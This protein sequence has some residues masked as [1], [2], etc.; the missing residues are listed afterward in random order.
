[1]QKYSSWCDAFFMVL[2]SFGILKC[3]MTFKCAFAFFCDFI[4]F[5]SH[6]LINLETDEF[7]GIHTKKMI[8]ISVLFYS[9]L[10]IFQQEYLNWKILFLQSN[11]IIYEQMII[12]ILYFA[13]VIWW[14]RTFSRCK[15]HCQWIRLNWLNICKLMW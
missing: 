13:W 3:E 10:L 1:M 7:Q 2:M 6:R 9:L 4:W 8:K 12:C 5:L 15:S 11:I 14:W